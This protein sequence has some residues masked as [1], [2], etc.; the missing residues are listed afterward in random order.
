MI[1]TSFPIQFRNADC[2]IFASCII[3]VVALAPAGVR[4]MHVARGRLLYGCFNIE[5]QVRR[6]AAS[7]YTEP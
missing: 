6:A 4:T 2:C 1:V 7:P 5:Q 3:I